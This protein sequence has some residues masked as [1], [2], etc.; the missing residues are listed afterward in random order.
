MDANFTEHQKYYSEKSSYNYEE[1]S[2]TY[3]QERYY[4]RR[5]LF[6]LTYSKELTDNCTNKNCTICYLNS[7]NDCFRCKSEKYE[8][9]IKNGLKVKI[10]GEEEQM[11]EEE[12]IEEWE[13][14][15]ELEE[16]LKEE[17]E[18]K[19]EKKEKKRRRRKN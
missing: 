13:E 7:P 11:E 17:K 10:C 8:I 5:T 1:T 19:E 6:K 14:I 4:G 2:T 9:K 3:I 12:T 15:E 18:L 16:L